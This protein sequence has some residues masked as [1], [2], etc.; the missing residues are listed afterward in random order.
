MNF[1]TSLHFF[2]SL[3]I[4][5]RRSCPQ[6]SEQNN[7]IE[8][9]HRHVVETGVTLLAQSHL[10]RR[11]WHYAFET[12]VYLIN[13]LPSRVSSNKSPFQQLFNR[14]PDYSFL[15]VFGCQC[16]PYLRPYNRHKM[17]FRSTSCTFLGYSPTHH[18][19]RCFDPLIDRVYIARH[20]R[21]NEQ[22]F[23][24]HPSNQTPPPTTPAS[25]YVS[26]F[27]TPPPFDTD[28]PSTHDTNAATAAPTDPAPQSDPQATSSAVPP[29]I[30][31]RPRPPNLR[32]NPKRTTPYD[33][34]AYTSTVS[35]TDPIEPKSFSVAN[36]SPD[37]QRAMNDEFTAL[38]KNGTWVL[39]PP[40]KNTN[41]IDCKW[42][43]R[44]KQDP[45]GNVVRHKARLVAKGYHQRAGIDF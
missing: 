9:R 30:P 28:P 21:F 42:V 45:Q 27:P 26:V 34:S 38:A 24:F 11:F 2:T 23:P 37:W 10:P 25:P 39:V 20:V 40:V 33:P 44:L 5:H 35:P 41:I 13:R 19:Y 3:G 29:T 16:F 18:G 32:P 8:R 1:E 14:R 43:Y 12:A 7:F 36:K 15:R 6:T 31:P 4:L 22:I 17:D